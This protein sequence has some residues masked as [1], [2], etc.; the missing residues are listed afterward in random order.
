MVTIIF[1]LLWIAV[2]GSSIAVPFGASGTAIGKSCIITGIATYVGAPGTIIAVHDT[3]VFLAISFRLLANSHVEH[4][5]REM[6]RAL[7]CGANLPAFSKTL[8]L[9]G[10]KYYMCVVVPSVFPPCSFY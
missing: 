8:F 2:V 9:D 7:F 4:T 3:A 5:R 6:L 1:G 10:Q